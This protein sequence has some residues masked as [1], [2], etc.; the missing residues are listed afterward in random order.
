M[1]LGSTDSGIKS[2]QKEQAA[3]AVAAYGL[4]RTVDPATAM[5]EEVYRT[6][7][8]VAYLGDIVRKLTQEQLVTDGNPSVWV[9]MFNDERKHLVNVTKSTV[10][11][12]IAERN[13]KVVEILGGHLV[14]FARALT[15][16]LGHDPDDAD[17]REIVS[18]Q[19][20]ALSA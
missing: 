7:G 10:D 8:S 14:T 15:M 12:K 20:R 4:P 2:A 19:F 18:Q 9:R 6:A 5:L 16:A 3:A 11:A 13:V 17:V 1:H